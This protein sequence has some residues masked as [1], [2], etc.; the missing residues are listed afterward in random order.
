MEFN[1]WVEEANLN[2]SEEAFIKL[3]QKMRDLKDMYLL[4]SPNNNEA[5]FVGQEDNYNWMYIYTSYQQLESNAPLIFEDGTQLYYV[6]VPT[7]ELLSWLVQHQSH[8][9]YGVRI[10]EGPF[11]FWISLRDLEG[12]IIEEGTSND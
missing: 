5:P 9:V 11:G 10:N 1:V 4:M 7:T 2:H 12:I 6:S 8:G 3:I